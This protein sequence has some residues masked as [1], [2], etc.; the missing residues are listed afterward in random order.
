MNLADGFNLLFAGCAVF[1]AFG[2]LAA[3]LRRDHHDCLTA[4]SACDASGVSSP[5]IGSLSIGP[6]AST[7]VSVFAIAAFAGSLAT[8]CLTEEGFFGFRDRK[9]NKDRFA[10]TGGSSGDTA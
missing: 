6:D 4:D 10:L 2:D 1:G 3:F 5:G 8:G 7:C 9:P